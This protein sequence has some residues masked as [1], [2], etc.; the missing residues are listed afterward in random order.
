MPTLVYK[1]GLL[2]PTA[3]A[4]VVSDQMQR[5]HRY[6]N[7]LIEIER[8]RRET[9][10]KLRSWMPEIENLE[11][12]RSVEVER[13]EL[14]RQAI[15]SQRASTRSRSDTAEQR[16]RAT[17]AREALREVS[18]LWKAARDA[19]R[20]DLELQEAAEAINAEAR[21]RMRAARAAN[22]VFWGTYLC[23]EAA[24]DEARKHARFEPSFRRWSGDGVV[25]VQ[26]QHGLTAAGA[27]GCEDTRLQIDERPRPCGSGRGK[28]RP[29]V[30]LRVGSSGRDP[31]WAE[32]PLIM[33]RPLPAG[34]VIQW[35]KVKRERLAGKD[36]WSLHLT[37]V[38]P[39]PRRD[40]GDC[41]QAMAV[42]VGW[43]RKEDGGIRVAYLVGTDGER[44]EVL[45]DPSVL[46]GLQQVEDLRSIRDMRLNGLRELLGPWF[47]DHAAELPE[48]L[49]SATE[50]L[51]QWRSPA[52]FA[53]LAIAWREHID[54]HGEALG[55]IYDL[56]EA[57]R[58]KDRHLWTWEVNLRDKVQARRREQYRV[59]AAELAGQYQTLVIERFSKSETQEYQPPESETPDRK[60]VHSQQ[61]QAATS[62][63][64]GCL[65]NAFARR[66]RVTAEMPPQWTTRTCRSCGFID[67]DWDP[68][69]AVEHRCTACGELADQDEQAGDNL[70]A[71]W[72]A[73][74][75]RGGDAESAGG[76]RVVDHSAEAQVSVPRA[77]KWGKR[78]RHSRRCSQGA[79]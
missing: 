71:L 6:Y 22:G 14:A 45:I 11:A 25:A 47:R 79:N 20:E 44:R 56:L 53:A 36:Q 30:R 9:Y 60:A 76:A 26:L 78:G 10:R 19:A 66:G 72:E 69:V 67:T 68:A 63:L 57:W 15:T 39:V 43:R 49:V 4:E 55:G 29:R 3:N 1:Y 62:I 74:R 35:A 18:S 2:P 51:A 5:A 23:V 50:H 16:Q 58:K 13:L 73:W 64:C 77:S 34:A 24:E 17:E 54:G 59:L 52:R 40:S 32:W 65:L 75:E 8:W 48:W 41:S 38:V 21:D 70:L 28:S 37:L 33:H 42:D 7:Q 12:W 46:S 27:L 31:V 61:T